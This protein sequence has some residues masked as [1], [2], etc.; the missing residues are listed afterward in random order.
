METSYCC[1]VLIDYSTVNEV[2]NTYYSLC[3]CFIYATKR[4][5]A[6]F[7]TDLSNLPTCTKGRRPINNTTGTAANHKTVNHRGNTFMPSAN[8][9]FG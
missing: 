6:V 7:K 8:Y 2:I 5:A 1:C 3:L 4:R 9:M